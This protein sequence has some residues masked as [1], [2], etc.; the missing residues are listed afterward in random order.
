MRETDAL[1]DLQVAM[2]QIA[3]SNDASKESQNSSRTLPQSTAS[4]C[5]GADL[6]PVRAAS[7]W[8][9]RCVPAE[10]PWSAALSVFRGALHV[11]HSLLLPPR[12]QILSAAMLSRLPRAA[13]TA[14][15]RQAADT[16][17]RVTAAHAAAA[18]AAPAMLASRSF[19][20]A[21]AAASSGPRFPGPITHNQHTTHMTAGVGQLT[22]IIAERAAGSYIYGKDG[23]KYLDFCTGIGVTNLGHCHPRVRAHRN[24]TE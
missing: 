23:K 21:P 8:C 16:A 5:H 13:T 17:S 9:P 18:S 4:L 12:F 22:S 11:A 15:K 6:F 14:I 2:S 19:A 3:R 24:S 10:S 20:A 1:V 7:S